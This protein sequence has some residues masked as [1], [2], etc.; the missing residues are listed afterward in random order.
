MKK[1]NTWNTWNT[2]YYPV[3]KKYTVGIKDIVGTKWRS[4]CYRCS[5]KFHTVLCLPNRTIIMPKCA[6]ITRMALQ[7]KIRA[8]GTGEDVEFE[9]RK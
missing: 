5:T 3:Y 7:H 8:V 1:W 4:T 9:V 2:Y 6:S